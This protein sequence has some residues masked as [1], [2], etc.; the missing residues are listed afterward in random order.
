MMFRRVPIVLFAILLFSAVSTHG[1]VTIRWQDNSTNEQGFHVERALGGGAFSR[2][3]SVGTNVTTFTDNSLLAGIVYRYRVRAYNAAG[4][5]AYSNIVIHDSSGALVS[6]DLVVLRD[7]TLSSTKSSVSLSLQSMGTSTSS[8]NRASELVIVASS[9]NPELVPHPE[10]RGPSTTSSQPTLLITR[11]G[12]KHGSATITVAATNGQSVSYQR[13]TVTVAAPSAGGT[14]EV[15]PEAARTLNSRLVNVSARA[16]AGSDAQNV[17]LG[18]NLTGQRS[19]VLLRAAGPG[20]SSFV[21]STA[22]PDPILSLFRGNLLLDENQDWDSAPGLSGAVNAGG[23]FPFKTSSRDAGLLQSL[24]PGSYTAQVRS[25]N[26][27]GL[28]LAELYHVD[29]E[30]ARPGRLSNLSCRAD[31]DGAEGGLIIGFTIRGSSALPLL[32]RAVGR[33]LLEFGV[34]GVIT[35]PRLA[36][37]RGQDRIAVAEDW[38]LKPELIEAG[39]AVGGFPLTHL[40]DAATLLTLEPG[41]YTVQISGANGKGGVVLAELYE[42]P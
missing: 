19:S 30:S 10:V 32:L 31:I 3:A 39:Y 21:G 13:F 36:L 22:M 2:L 7:Q 24:A 17:V 1:R 41:T 20:L 26:S 40:S 34:D 8:G 37:Y 38:E 11:A 5:S 9:S 33:S 15:R 18:F 14:T 42:L 25:A 16:L 29:W 35:N 4:S 23:A 28:V 6:P 12:G 27:K